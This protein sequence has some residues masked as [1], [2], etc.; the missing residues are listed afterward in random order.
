[1]L[2]RAVLESCRLGAEHDVAIV[3]G[4]ASGRRGEIRDEGAVVSPADRMGAKRQASKAAR[5]KEDRRP[6]L[7]SGD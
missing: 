3:G 1:M 6:L 7:C 2:A 5:P 4:A